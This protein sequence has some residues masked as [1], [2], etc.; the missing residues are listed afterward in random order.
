MFLDTNA[1]G[2]LPTTIDYVDKLVR[3]FGIPL[4]VAAIVWLVRTYDTGTRVMKSLDERTAVTQQIV[5]TIQNNHLEHLSE[6]INGIAENGKETGK[7]L[8]SIDKTLGIL[9]D[10]GNRDV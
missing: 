5:S 7:V 6:A 8:A 2:S 3:I 9:A 10:R 1:V 4:I